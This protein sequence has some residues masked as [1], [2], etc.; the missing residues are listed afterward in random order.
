MVEVVRVTKKI[1]DRGLL[2]SLVD[3]DVNTTEISEPVKVPIIVAE[4]SMD[5][6]KK[7]DEKG[8]PTKAEC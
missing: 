6:V 2:R 4:G 8:N 7:L 5:W 3:S 1:S